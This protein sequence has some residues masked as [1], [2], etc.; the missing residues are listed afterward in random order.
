MDYGDFLLPVQAHSIHAE[1]TGD[2]LLI[3]WQWESQLMSPQCLDYVSAVRVSL[4]F[5]LPTGVDDLQHE[6]CREGGVRVITVAWGMGH[7][8]NYW[9]YHIGVGYLH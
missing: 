4:L 7:S 9:L 8:S 2:L 3:F 1:I 6:G 5:L